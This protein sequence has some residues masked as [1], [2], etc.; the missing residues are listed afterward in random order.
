M[1]YNVPVVLFLALCQNPSPV[2]RS[3]APAITHPSRDDGDIGASAANMANPN[4]VFMTQ[5]DIFL[6]DSRPLLLQI[7][8]DRPVRTMRHPRVTQTRTNWLAGYP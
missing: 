1:V 2:A 6:I 7:A 8:S 4:P 3:N 5:L